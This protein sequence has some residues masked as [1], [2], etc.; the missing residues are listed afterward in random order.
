MSFAVWC[1]VFD[2]QPHDQYTLPYSAQSPISKKVKDFNTI[3]DIWEEVHEIA[4]SDHKY[5]IGQQLYYLLPLFANPHYIIDDK[6]YTLINEYHYITDYHIPLGTTLDDT[7][8][9]KLSMF[10]IIKNEMAIALKH[11]AEKNDNSKS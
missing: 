11:K 9:L 7:D 6:Y 4:K 2:I 1:W 10:S 8:A 3:N 5:S